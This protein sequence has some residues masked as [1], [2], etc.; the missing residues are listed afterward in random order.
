MGFNVLS[1]VHHRGGCQSLVGGQVSFD[2]ER[3]ESRVDPGDCGTALGEGRGQAGMPLPHGGLPGHPSLSLPDPQLKVII[4]QSTGHP[5]TF[6]CRDAHWAYHLPPPHQNGSPRRGTLPADFPAVSPLLEALAVGSPSAIEWLWVHA[7]R[8]ETQACPRA[9]SQS[10]GQAS[11]R[12]GPGGHIC[13]CWQ[14]LQGNL[15]QASLSSPPPDRHGA[16]G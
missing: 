11:Q 1:P 14:L 5:L 8:A 16:C 2:K 9:P 4:P 6:S 10:A 13:Y 12:Q 7:W 15:A 3:E